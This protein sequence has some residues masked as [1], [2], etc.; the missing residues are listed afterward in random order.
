MAALNDGLQMAT[1]LAE[2]DSIRGI[3]TNLLKVIAT[4]TATTAISKFFSVITAGSRSAISSLK[5]MTEGL[6]NARAA[7]SISKASKATQVV[8][9]SNKSFRLSRKSESVG[10]ATKSYK[11]VEDVGD[12][13]RSASSIKNVSDTVEKTTKATK[14]KTGAILYV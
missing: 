11:A 5:G 1:K 7:S 4:L 2:N 12:I 10:K 8:T 13:A 9:T 14:E 6:M 3:T